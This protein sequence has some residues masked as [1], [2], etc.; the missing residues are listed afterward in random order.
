MSNPC[1]LEK[2]C[3]GTVVSTR[4]LDG[5]H[6]KRFTCGLYQSPTLGSSGILDKNLSRSSYISGTPHF[7][8]FLIYFGNVFNNCVPWTLIDLCLSVWK[9]CLVWDFNLGM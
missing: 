3:N 5:D 6:V 9:L 8:T 1:M 2:D 4:E 7:D